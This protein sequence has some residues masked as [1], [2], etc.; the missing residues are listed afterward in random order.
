MSWIVI[1]YFL[2]GHIDIA[3]VIREIMDF[4]IILQNAMRFIYVA[5]AIKTKRE[6]N[7]REPHKTNI[8]IQLNVS[9]SIECNCVHIY[10]DVRWMRKM[11]NTQHLQQS[12]RIAANEWACWRTAE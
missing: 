1:Y 4:S 12:V 6:V 2:P 7:I 9:S 8:K 11:I 5:L 3:R 10:T